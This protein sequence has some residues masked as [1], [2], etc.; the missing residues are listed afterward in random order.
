[1]SFSAADVAKIAKLARIKVTDEEKQAL[2]QQIGSI[3]QFVEQ[4][5]EVD[6]GEAATVASVIEQPLPW[7]ADAVTDG[8]K[9]QEITRNAPAS[10]Y[11]CFVVPKVIGE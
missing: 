11:D 3:L 5:N 8:G 4:L 9:A 2:S 7:R 6:T 1:M 10:E